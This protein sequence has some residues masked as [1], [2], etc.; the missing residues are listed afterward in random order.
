MF[1][2]TELFQKEIIKIRFTP[3]IIS[4]LKRNLTNELR[5]KVKLHS[6]LLIFPQTKPKYYI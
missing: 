1:R 4:G 6:R 2:K 5:N 3:K